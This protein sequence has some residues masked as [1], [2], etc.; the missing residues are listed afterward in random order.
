MD[1]T[2]PLYSQ[3]I[4]EGIKEV[5]TYVKK[6]ESNPDIVALV[7]ISGWNGGNM[8]QPSSNLPWFKGWKVTHKDGNA[9]GTMLLEALNYILATSYP[10]DKPLHP[11]LQEVH[12]SSVAQSC[13]ILCNPMDCS[14]PSL[15]VHHQLPEF[16]QIHVHWVSNVIQPSHSLLSPSPPA[17]NLSQ[18]QGLFKWVSSSQ[19]VA[20]VLEFQLQHHSFQWTSRTDLL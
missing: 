20:K 2:E 18:H 14:T 8:L 3:K 11:S 5:N 12:F 9:S 17:F 19:Q 6:V 16:T 1:S 10:T 15:P 7:P 4:Y 13:P